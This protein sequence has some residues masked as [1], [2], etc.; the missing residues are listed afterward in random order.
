MYDKIQVYG[1]GKLKQL[2]TPTKHAIG[3]LTI[4]IFK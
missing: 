1:F 2:N 4:D 3:M